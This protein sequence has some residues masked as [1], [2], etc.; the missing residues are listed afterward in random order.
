MLKVSAYGRIVTDI[1]LEQKDEI[2]YTN[3]LFAS[4]ERSN[5]TFIRCVAFEPIAKLLSQYSGKGDR[6]ML[7]GDLI[8]DKYIDKKK[9]K[10]IDT[11]K[12]KVNTFDFVETQAESRK[13]RMKNTQ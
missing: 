11:F 5:T 12:I 9:H 13:N 4:H 2:L 1:T 8:P 6:M 3:F 10:N 7:T